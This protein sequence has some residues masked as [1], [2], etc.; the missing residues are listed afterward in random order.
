MN[1]CLYCLKKRYCST[2]CYHC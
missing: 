2:V 1:H